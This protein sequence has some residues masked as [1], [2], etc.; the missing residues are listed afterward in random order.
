MSKVLQLD[1]NRFWL[2]TGKFKVA[3]V[4]GRAV[5]IGEAATQPSWYVLAIRSA[6]ERD[7]TIFALGYLRFGSADFEV[8]IPI[9]PD[10]EQMC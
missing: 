7:L 4:L 6:L 10:E 5:P 8:T 2:S 3:A 1:L 9:S